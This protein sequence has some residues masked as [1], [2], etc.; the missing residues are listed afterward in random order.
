MNVVIWQKKYILS[1]RYF[2]NTKIWQIYKEFLLEH[3]IKHKPLTSEEFWF[4]INRTETCVPKNEFFSK[5]KSIFDKKN[6][7]NFIQIHNEIISFLIFRLMYGLKWPKK[8]NQILDQL[9][10]NLLVKLDQLLVRFA[11]FRILI[12]KIIRNGKNLAN[13]EFIYMF[14]QSIGSGGVNWPCNEEL[15]HNNITHPMSTPNN[16]SNN[17]SVQSNSN[18]LELYSK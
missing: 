11:F 10:A 7:C 8:W 13:N 2:W 9:E 18:R 15:A 14:V 12:W 6:F 16:D 17:S 4:V 5:Y 3:L 1:Y